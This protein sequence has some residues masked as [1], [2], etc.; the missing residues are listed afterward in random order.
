MTP[1][2]QMG[3]CFLGN[4]VVALFAKSRLGQHTAESERDHGLVFLL[5]GT[6]DEV[7]LGGE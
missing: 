3:P 2:H 6:V 4:S 5:Q 7:G 1:P